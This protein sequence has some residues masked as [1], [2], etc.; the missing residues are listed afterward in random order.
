[1]RHKFLYSIAIVAACSLTGCGSDSPSGGEDPVVPP[2]PT[3]DPEEP[4]T[5]DD[6]AGTIYNGI[7]LPAQW[8]ILRS[9]TSDIRKGMSPFYLTTRPTTVNIAVGRQLF[10]DNFLIENTT[11]SRKFHYPE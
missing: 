2:T 7:K 9:A 4:T 3:P 10:V 11:L 1:M 8:P 5:P 6:L